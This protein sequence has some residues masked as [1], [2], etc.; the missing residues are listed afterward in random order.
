LERKWLTLLDACS[1]HQT[2]IARWCRN[3]H[4]SGIFITPSF[5]YALELLL[6]ADNMCC[7]TALGGSKDLVA[8]LEF[9]C[10]AS[11]EGG[12]RFED[13]TREFR[14]SYPGECG[15]VL[16]FAADLKEI[17]EVGG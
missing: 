10:L 3:E 9:W 2:S 13:D 11:R 16:V 12:R 7:V 15:L 4:T 14:T 6:C 8:L 17:E 1:N 5:R